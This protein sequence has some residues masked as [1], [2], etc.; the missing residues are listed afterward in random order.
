MNDGIK[1]VEID[2]KEGKLSKRMIALGDGVYGVEVYR[3]LKAPGLDLFKRVKEELGIDLKNNP[4]YRFCSDGVE[5]DYGISESIYEEI[6]VYRIVNLSDVVQ[7]V[8][9]PLVIPKPI[10]SAEQEEEEKGKNQ[11][12]L[13][14]LW[15]NAAKR[16]E[17]KERYERF[18]SH[19]VKRGSYS[20][21]E[22]YPEKAQDEA[23]LQLTE[24]SYRLE[25]LSR[26]QS[27]DKSKYLEAIR[28]YKCTGSLPKDSEWHEYTDEELIDLL[29]HQDEEYIATNNYAYNQ[30]QTTHQNLKTLG[31]HGEK[32]SYYPL[33]EIVEEN[34]KTGRKKFN[35]RALA[36]DIVSVP[37]NAFVFLLNHTKKPLYAFVGKSVVA[38]IQDLI[39][40]SKQSAAAVY[41]DLATHR[42]Q[43][44]KDI[45]E[46]LMDMALII[47]NIEREKK[48]EKPLKPNALAYALKKAFVP[49]FQAI[50]RAKEGNIIIASAKAI[51]IEESAKDHERA[52]QQQQALGIALVARKKELMDALTDLDLAWQTEK[53]DSTRQHI[54]SLQ[55][56]IREKIDDIDLCIR[57]NNEHPVPGVVQT[58]PISLSIHE[59][60]NRSNIT[61]VVSGIATVARVGAISY[62]GPKITRWIQKQCGEMTVQL[63]DTVIEEQHVIPGKV[64]VRRKALEDLS[65]G[66]AYDKTDK[67]IDYYAHGAGNQVAAPAR[68]HFRGVDFVWEGKEYSGVCLDNWGDIQYATMHLSSNPNSSDK[69]F[70][71]LARVYSET[72]HQPMTAKDIIDKIASSPDPEAAAR[73]FSEG[74]RFWVDYD[75]DTSK[76]AEGWVEAKDILVDFVTKTSEHVETVKRVVGGD[77]AII[78]LLKC[79]KVVDPRILSAIIALSGGELGDLY[80][81]LRR[82]KSKT[83][84]QRQGLIG[85]TLKPI[86]KATDKPLQERQTD[87][88]YGFTGTRRGDYESSYNE[89]DFTPDT[90]HKTR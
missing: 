31:K 10:A 20:V 47:E 66:E 5:D 69:L 87:N 67:V 56:M 12:M 88:T 83:E 9:E 70:E 48:G 64:E 63:P 29:M 26:A 68:P 11:D 13:D 27:G 53:K 35:A 3:G 42:Y 75:G 49:R 71:I 57:A 19:L 90:P 81:L 77:I 2:G 16:K 62:L 51:E 86:E 17:Y 76:V 15:G 32:G 4:N 1:R 73:K 46:Q 50:F 8:E 24:F 72:T 61:R 85:R 54:E 79:S 84:L 38:P 39:F 37:T 41:K 59:E 82:T 34:E 6:V 21:I 30:H 74:I 18:I 43:A 25:R 89:E 58:D 40:K 80:D 52:K 14:K 33:R 45:F 36:S 23:F 44:R 78:P 55:K 7:R 22:D 60:A 28:L 65:I